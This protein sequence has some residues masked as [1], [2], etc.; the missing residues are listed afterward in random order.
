MKIFIS[1]L[2]KRIEELISPCLLFEY[3]G[4]ATLAKA[5]V[6]V[7]M[8]D[9]VLGVT[10]AIDLVTSLMDAPKPKKLVT[11]A[12]SLAE[13]QSEKIV[14]CW[15]CGEGDHTKADPNC[16]KKKEGTSLKA[17]LKTKTSKSSEKVGGKGKK[18]VTCSH[19][20]KSS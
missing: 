11:T 14:Y 3:Y 12:G 20:G 8:F 10:E 4:N 1:K 16:S 5:F 2:D 18:P 7:E 15:V 9:R 13:A 17:K 19:Y 6:E